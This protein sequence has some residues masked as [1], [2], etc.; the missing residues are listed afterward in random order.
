[1]VSSPELFLQAK[2]YL[3]GH[4]DELVNDVEIILKKRNPGEKLNN[5]FKMY[6]TKISPGEINYQV[7]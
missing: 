4:Q 2:K 1:M 6:N 5:T 3:S 7:G